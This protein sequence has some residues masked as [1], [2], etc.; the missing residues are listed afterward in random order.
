M[1]PIG[2][3]AL[4]RD[5]TP[6]EKAT[7]GVDLFSI[8]RVGPPFAIVSSL[9]SESALLRPARKEQC[10]SMATTLASQGSGL[11]DVVLAI[12]LGKQVGWPEDKWMP[13]QKEADNAARASALNFPWR[14]SETGSGFRCDTVR[15]YDLIIDALETS[16]GSE[17][18][19]FIAVTETKGN[20]RSN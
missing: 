6:L 19:A 10:S 2:L 3:G 12:R 14:D 1:I 9:C 7:A 4:P 16:G 8:S 17:R 13:L 5:V 18:A 20:A 15:G 11:I